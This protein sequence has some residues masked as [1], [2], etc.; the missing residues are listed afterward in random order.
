MSRLVFK[1]VLFRRF[2]VLIFKV[3]SEMVQG[4]AASDVKL[5]L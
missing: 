2:K 1:V 4:H 3:S 5:L